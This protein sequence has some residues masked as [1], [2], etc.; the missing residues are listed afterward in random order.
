MSK[1]PNESDIQDY[2]NNILKENMRQLM[3]NL[4]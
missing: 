3:I 1:L 2:F 4:Q